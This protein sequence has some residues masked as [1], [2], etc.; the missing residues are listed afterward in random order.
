MK[1][2]TYD[3]LRCKL[4]CYRHNYFLEGIYILCIPHAAVWP[5]DIDR[6]ADV[7]NINDTESH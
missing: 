3:K 5:G 2:L 6:A 7:L 4:K 1:L